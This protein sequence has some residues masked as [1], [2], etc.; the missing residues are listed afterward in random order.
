[1]KDFKISF[2]IEEIPSYAISYNADRRKS[3]EM[4]AFDGKMDISIVYDFNSSPLMQSSNISLGDKVELV[5]MPHRIE[6]YING[7]LT[8]E[9]WPAGKILFNKDDNIISDLTIAVEEYT[10]K[11]KNEPSIVS[12]FENADG[13]HPGG[14]V[15]V[16]DC[17]PYRKDDE[18]HILYLK[19][20]R[21]HQSKWRLGAHQW[22]HI[23]TKDF[24]EWYVH[25]TAI[26]I[27]DPK[28]GSI[29]T[30]SWIREGKKEY[31]F[32]TVRMYDWSPAPIMRS[33][34]DDGYH[35]EKDEKF[36]FTLPDKYDTGRARDPKVIKDDNGLY[37]MFITT[38]LMEEKR[39]CLAH[40]VSDDLD[41]W[42]DTGKPVYIAE[43]ETEPECPDY[44]FYCGKYYLVYSL[45]GKA[46]YMY[47]DKP[48][49]EFKVP[50]D[51]SIPC[52]RVPKGAIWG[53][54]LVFVGYVPWEGR[55]AGTMEFKRAKAKDNGELVFE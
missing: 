43:D 36:G 2:V 50:S 53:E 48:F 35:F 38:S 20:R 3:F 29:C 5:L 46:Y 28:E 4:Q 32:Y 22:N 42:R 10:E 47:S 21:H 1:M 6:L 26:E 40:F 8:D 13:W 34:S 7:V 30:G 17:M 9:E 24:K 18:F 52:T 45:H 51:P 44:F 31:L 37:H 14:G 33:I 49:D 54:E 19:D 25:P 23:S 55:Y 41:N 12:S 16:G 27:T 15:F 39:G 11:K